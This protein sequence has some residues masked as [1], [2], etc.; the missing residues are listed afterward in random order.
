MLLVPG[1]LAY[2]HALAAL[3]E[4]VGIRMRATRVLQL[5]V[6]IVGVVAMF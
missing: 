3:V 5:A 2:R 6:V 4:L 1:A